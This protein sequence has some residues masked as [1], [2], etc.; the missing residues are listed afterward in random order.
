MASL[1]GMKNI[2]TKVQDG[3]VLI[4][5]EFRLEKPTQEALDDVRAAVQRVRGDLPGALRDPVV[6]KIDLAGAPILTY[7]VASSRMDDE[8]LSWFVDNE[9]TK[10]VLAVRGVGS[11]ARVGGVT[12]EVR[13]EI[14]PAQAAG[15]ERHR[16]RHLAP[17]AQRAAGRLAAGVPTS[18]ACRAVG[19]HH[20]HGAERAELARM[21]VPLSDG[22]RIRLDQVATVMRH[23]GR[24]AQRR[25]AERQAGGRLRGGA[26]ARRRRSR[27]GRRRA[28]RAGEAARAQ[29]PRPARSPRPSTSSTR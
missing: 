5:V 11:V 23:R 27:R 25:T 9:V 19:A 10:A 22:R 7:T 26:L 1:Q 8:A 12:R 16:R 17:A 13:V 28:R 29:Q 21:E 20:R 2:Y 6:G 14:D 18:A 24:T 15:A 3:L 4:T